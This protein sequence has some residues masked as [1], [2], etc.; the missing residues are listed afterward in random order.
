MKSL[1]EFILD[2]GTDKFE[3]YLIEDLKLLN[4]CYANTFGNGITPLY[5][6]YKLPHIF[7]SKNIFQNYKFI[8]GK[9]NSEILKKSKN[10]NDGDKIDVEF[11]LVQ[12][13][14]KNIK[15]TLYHSPGNSVGGS[16]SK[17]ENNIIYLDVELPENTS[18]YHR[19]E[20]GAIVLHELLH[21]YEEYI[22]NDK[23]LPSIFDELKDDYYNGFRN[24]NFPRNILD[25]MSKEDKEYSVCV[26]NIA[27][28]RYF[29]NKHE[30]FAYIGIL[31]YKLK[32]ILKNLK[33]NYNNFKYEDAI[34]ELKKEY[35]WKNYLDF[36]KFVLYIDKIDDSLLEEAYTFICE[37]KDKVIKFYKEQFEIQKE[38]LTK[39]LKYKP[40]KYKE[41]PANE[42]RKECKDIWIKFKSKFDIEFVKVYNKCMQENTK[43][44]L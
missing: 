1:V 28:S 32:N 42:I 18:K 17:L 3:N 29:Y 33:P 13:Y 30:I 39:G 4:I 14:P 25:K 12:E 6:N 44:I 10:F 16:F 19:N 31:E 22:R 2:N 7:E 40:L 21:G 11:K 37:Q 8:V 23:G 35:V 9:I 36:G 34:N 27:I 41:K 43:L 24:L 15:I 20:L 38:F 5:E 26:K